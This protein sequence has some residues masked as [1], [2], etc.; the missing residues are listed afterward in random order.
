MTRQPAAGSQPRS[1][2]LC[3]G[4]MRLIRHA[5]WNTARLYVIPMHKGTQP[6]FGREFQWHRYSLQ[7]AWYWWGFGREP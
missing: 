4:F 1:Y 5:Y 7:I 3:L 6:I 2:H